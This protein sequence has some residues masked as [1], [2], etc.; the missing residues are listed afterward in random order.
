M[1]GPLV[2]QH[3]PLVPLPEYAEVVKSV[4][5]LGLGASEL[6]KRKICR[7]AKELQKDHAPKPVDQ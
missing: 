5:Y 7:V 3:P 2:A 4:Y 1:V 6:D